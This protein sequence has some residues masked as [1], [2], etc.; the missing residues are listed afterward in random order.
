MAPLTVTMDR[1][2]VVD[3]THPFERFDTVA[4]FQRRPW[5][6]DQP[7]NS[8]DDLFEYDFQFGVAKEGSTREVGT[9]VYF[10]NS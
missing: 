9:R 10:V 8:L 6:H 3:F 2:E 1:E 5:N 7:V 4:V